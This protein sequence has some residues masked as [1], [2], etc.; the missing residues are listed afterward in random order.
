[1]NT[2]TVTGEIAY[3][4]VKNVRDGTPYSWAL[5]EYL[6]L[7]QMGVKFDLTQENPTAAALTTIGSLQ[8]TERADTLELAVPG[9]VESLE[10]ANEYNI[11]SYNLNGANSF[12]DLLWGVTDDQNLQAAVT[13]DPTLAAVKVVA[14][15]T[16]L[17][18]AAP[19]VT[20]Y[21]AASNWHVYGGVGQQLSTVMDAGI[22]AAQA[23]APGKPIFVTETG[24]SSAGYGT[25]TWGVAD[26][27]T[28]G[29]IL[30]NALLDAYADGASKTFIYDLMDDPN[31]GS[32]QEDDFGLF[33]SNGTPKMAAIDIHNL[34]TILADDGTGTVSDGALAYGISGLPSTAT[35]M[36]LEKSN[37]TFDLVI[38]NTNAIISNGTTDVSPPSSAVTVTFANVLTAINVYDPISEAAAQQTFHNANTASFFL[39]A[40][41]IILELPG[42]I[43]EPATI[44]GS[45]S[46]ITNINGSYTTTGTLDSKQVNVGSTGVIAPNGGSLLIEGAVDGTGAI[47][48]GTGDG[49]VL[50]GAVNDES[51]GLQVSFTGTGG[52]LEVSDP[53]QFDD[54]IS[55]YQSGDTVEVYDPAAKDAAPTSSI[56]DGNIVLT[57]SDGSILTFAG[58]AGPAP[59]E[60]EIDQSPACYCRGTL[61]LIDKGQRAVETLAIGDLAVTE[62]GE[63]RP[64]IWIGRRSYGRRFLAGNPHIR[65]VRFRAGSLGNGLPRRDLFVSPEHAMYLD[66]IL[67][68]ARYLVNGTSIVQER[69]LEC[70]DY[71]H[72]ELDSHD[73]LLAEGAPSE[74]FFDDNSRRVFHNAAEFETMYPHARL[75]TCYCAPRVE[76]GFELEAVRGRLQY[77][78]IEARTL[79]TPTLS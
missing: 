25:A 22:T 67:I 47:N 49:V 28:Q 50:E 58:A 46:N 18:S 32:T 68:P 42:S 8:D 61:I 69:G 30:T 77:I 71:Y 12:G 2:A 62:S 9:S 66:G 11:S 31:E 56:V 55:G 75:P 36:L 40:D 1:M 13:T 33:Q 52:T 76:D 17:V 35:S 73:V 74:S 41:P 19:V 48:I 70:V 34:L 16:A 43:A 78:G 59:S 60:I 24:I 27:V 72:V 39:S 26:Q 6:A 44:S 29:L 53:S 63:A 51:E 20:P 57:S 79:L 5:P 38:W 15:S 14:A 45:T 23:S 3:L 7:A 37:G 10:G 54:V 65:P 64:I 4:D 21:V